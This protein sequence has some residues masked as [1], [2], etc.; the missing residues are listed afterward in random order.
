MEFSAENVWNWSDPLVLGS[1]ATAV[2]ASSTA[3]QVWF[4]ITNVRAED[5]KQRTSR[6]LDFIFYMARDPGVSQMFRD[7]RKIRRG[8][9]VAPTEK[10]DRDVVIDL[11]NFYESLAIG[12]HTGAMAENLIKGW[13]RS[14]LVQDWIDLIPFVSD[15]RRVEMI[16][17]AWNIMEWLALRWATKSERA[18]IQA[19]EKVHKAPA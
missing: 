11:L 12:I 1:V 8:G 4:Q 13:W 15:Y 7:F 6:A 9:R 19:A 5:R 14:S 2:I 18:A 3:V 16:P 17:N 10:P